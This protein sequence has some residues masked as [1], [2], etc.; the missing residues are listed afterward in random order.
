MDIEKRIDNLTSEL[1]VFRTG[2]LSALTD[3]AQMIDIVPAPGN[4]FDIQMANRVSVTDVSPNT[5]IAGQINDRVAYDHPDVKSTTP[6]ES[7][8][9][10]S[11][12]AVT[13]PEETMTIDTLNGLAEWVQGTSVELGAERTAMFLDI[14]EMMGYIPGCVKT[15]LEKIIPV[16]GLQEVVST[17]SVKKQLQALKE[18]AKLL[19][20]RRTYD[21]IMLQIISQGMPCF[22]WPGGDMPATNN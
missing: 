11:I 2:L 4:C 12:A 19:D 16:N 5:A 7:T 14:A 22:R 3:I 18:L 15:T 21:F 20:K 1:V 17:Y 10:Q 8:S 9:H 6:A 13:R